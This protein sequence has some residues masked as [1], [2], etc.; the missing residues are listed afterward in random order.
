MIHDRI[1]ELKQNEDAIILAH[2]YVDGEIQKIADYVGDSFYLA[3]VAKKLNNRTI[4]IAGVYFMGESVK[5]LNPDKTVRMVDIKADCP[6]AHMVTVEKIKEMREKYDDLAVVCY[7]NSTAEIK[8]H[9]DICVTSSNAVNIVSQLKEKNIFFVPDQNLGAYVARFVKEKNIIL[10]DGYCPVHNK[11]RAN[12]LE[13]LKIKYKKAKVLCHPECREEVL[14]LSD[15]IGSTKG[16]IQEVG[17]YKDENEFII[18]TEE[19]I[20]SELFSKYP[21]KKF[22]YLNDFVCDDMKMPTFEKLESTLKNKENE[23]F[24]DEDIAKKA[25]VALNRMLEL[26]V[27]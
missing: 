5:I 15:Y 19:G 12:E 23:I 21:T 3:Q 26:G 1:K 11:I 4:V 17:K 25:L 24:V 20:S 8:S 9:C 6:M 7:I 14:A 22:Y 27:K 10:N 16:I 2:Y 18:V 13:D